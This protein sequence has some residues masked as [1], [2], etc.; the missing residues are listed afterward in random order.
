MEIRPV[1]PKSW[2]GFK[3]TRIFRGVAYQ[4]TV[5]R[6]GDG[7]HVV[8]RVNG[9]PCEGAVVPPPSDGQHEVRVEAVLA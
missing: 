1:V 4:I 5:K 7:N 9:K 8:L 6:E 3:A 2:Q